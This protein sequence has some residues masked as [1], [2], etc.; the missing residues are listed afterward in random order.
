V[1]I[2]PKKAGMYVPGTGHPIV[3]HDHLTLQPPDVV[4]VMNPIYKAEIR[5]T[6]QG[7]GLQPKILV[8]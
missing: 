6:L 3:A 7:M 1:D 5:Q 4:V 8:A 2:N